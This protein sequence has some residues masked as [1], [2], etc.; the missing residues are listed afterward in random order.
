MSIFDV[1]GPVMTGP[2][3]SHTAGAAKIGR[4]AKLIFQE[5]VNKAK[6]SLHGSFAETY[7]GHG[8]DRAVVGGILGFKPDDERLKSSLDIA[9]EREIAVEF[10]SITLKDV[11]PNT[12]RIELRGERRQLSVIGSSIGGGDIIVSRIDN[13]EV[14][15]SG[16]YPTLWILH[17]DKPGEVGIIT[18]VLGYYKINIAFMRVFRKKRGTVG[19]SIIELDQGVHKEIITELEKLEDIIQVRYIPPL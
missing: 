15:I 1:M 6:V 11:H 9:R 4:L 7:R 8:T 16:K 14:N 3:S 10:E 12:A 5:Q 19:S 13:Y 17:Q 2:S 18:S